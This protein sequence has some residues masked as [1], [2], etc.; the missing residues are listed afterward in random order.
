MKTLTHENH[1]S[2]LLTK[3][4]LLIAEP[5][6][7]PWLARVIITE[8]LFGKKTLVSESKPVETIR[9]YHKQFLSLLE[10]LDIKV[11]EVV[12]KKG[13]LHVFFYYLPGD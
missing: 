13:K 12:E 1:L 4:G 5:R 3:T 9:Q 6:F 2:D 10:S 8:L 7:N 11:E